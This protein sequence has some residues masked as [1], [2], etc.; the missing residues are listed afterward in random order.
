MEEAPSCC[1]SQEKRME[2]GAAAVRAAKAAGYDSVGTIE[3]LVDENGYYFMELNARVQVEHPVT[4]MITGIDIIKTQILIAGGYKLPYKQEDVPLLG[5]AIECRINAEDPTRNF[6]PSIGTI[7]MLHVPGGPGIRFDSAMFVGY[8]IP[9]Q[10]DS[11][12]GKLIACGQTREIAIAKM[13][14]ALTE[15]VVDG[16]ETNIDFEFELLHNEDVV[17]GNLDT[18]LIARI[19]EE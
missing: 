1:L 17:S 8:T 9:P 2:I 18:G 12:I 16:V 13:R 19:M 5:H 4:E 7:D 6:M 3:F 10:Y 14:S 15:L 11:M